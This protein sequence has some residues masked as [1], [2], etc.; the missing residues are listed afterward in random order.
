[1]ELLSEIGDEVFT[2]FGGHAVS[3][4]FTVKEDKIQDLNKEVKKAYQEISHYEIEPPVLWLD[5]ELD[6]ENIDWNLF[7][8]L[9]K[10]RPFG[11][12]NPKPVFLL[13][14]LEIFNTRTFGN[15][16]IHSEI[17]FRKD[18]G[19]IIRAIGFFMA[20][21]FDFSLDKGAKVDLAASVEKNIFNGYAELRLRIVD[22]R[23]AQ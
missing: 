18:N 23:K 17:N 10:F 4:G 20:E 21:R 5:A 13:R 3:A 15:G 9:D 2:E 7:S 16:G 11:R 1:V 8:L 6:L 22:I 19:E 12:D 14:D